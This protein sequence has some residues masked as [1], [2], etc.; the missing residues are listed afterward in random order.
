MITCSTLTRS[1]SLTLHEPSTSE[2]KIHLKY[3]SKYH[4]GRGKKPPRGRSIHVAAGSVKRPCSLQIIQFRGKRYCPS[5]FPD[6][7][8]E[9]WLA[10]RRAEASLQTI[11][12]RG[13][14]HLNHSNPP[15]CTLGLNNNK[16]SMAESNAVR[17]LL[18]ELSDTLKSKAEE[19]SKKEEDTGGNGEISLKLPFLTNIK[20]PV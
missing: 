8:K 3:N 11:Q 12:F 4:F 9:E 19:L 7:S 14:R 20:T 2:R 10:L 17:G 18:L 5:L 1:P 15:Y 13:K 6:I 16:R